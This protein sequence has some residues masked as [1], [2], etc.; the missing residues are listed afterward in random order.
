MTNSGSRNREDNVT[1]AQIDN[2]NL[3]D[4]VNLIPKSPLIGGNGTEDNDNVANN[5]TSLQ[6]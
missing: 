1:E 5:L 4:R 2:E 6:N 3:I